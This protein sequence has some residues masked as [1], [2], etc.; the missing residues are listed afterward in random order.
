[1][2]F[3]KKLFSGGE[4]AGGGGEKLLGSEDYNGYKITAV[5]MKHGGE[6]ILAGTVTKEIGGEAKTHKFVRA[7]RL[8]GAEMA[9]D[10]ALAK[11]RQLV[12]EQGDKLFS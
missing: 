10:A 2:S 7:D 5:E 8:P 1:M 4:G 12:D 11:G 6:F 9:K 3:L